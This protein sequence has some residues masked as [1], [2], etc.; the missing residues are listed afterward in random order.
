MDLEW[1]KERAWVQVLDLEW[2]WVQV[3]DLEWEKERVWVWV[4]G[5]VLE[6]ELA[7]ESD[8]V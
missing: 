7:W 8:L 2:V 4:L 1:E 6:G 3:L 5:W